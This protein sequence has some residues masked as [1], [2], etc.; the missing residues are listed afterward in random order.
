[1][2]VDLRRQAPKGR[3]IMG[4]SS[5]LV[6][7]IA[8]RGQA[9]GDKNLALTSLGIAQF[10][11]RYF[12]LCFAA[13]LRPHLAPGFSLG[14][15]VKIRSISRETATAMFSPQYQHIAFAVSR[16]NVHF[17]TSFPRLKP[18]K[19]RGYLLPPLRGEIRTIVVSLNLV[20]VADI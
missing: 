6:E 15:E 14:L 7:I 16:L 20:A 12:G 17:Q 4:K 10:S 3:E 19:A 18:A 8:P 9:R 13:Q 1:L 2:I 5:S 11:V